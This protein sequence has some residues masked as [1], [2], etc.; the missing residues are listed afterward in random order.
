MRSSYDLEPTQT[1]K[2]SGATQRIS[3]AGNK[4]I[5]TSVNWTNESW[6]WQ[7]HLA[8]ERAARRSV[9]GTT[10]F[11]LDATSSSTPSPKKRLASNECFTIKWTPNA[12]SKLR[13]QSVTDQQ[14]LDAV[15]CWPAAEGALILLFPKQILAAAS[16]IVAIGWV[17]G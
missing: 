11:M 17:T 4:P 16:S 5:A 2:A 14:I 15:N 13:Q 7:L 9:L 10:R 3:G 8:T 1:W 12:I 6:G